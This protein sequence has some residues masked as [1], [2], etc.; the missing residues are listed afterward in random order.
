M[1]EKT[2]VAEEIIAGAG[3][4]AWEEVRLRLATLE[5]RTTWLSTVRPNGVPHVVPVFAPWLDGAL[6]F[7]TGQNTQKERNIAHNPTCA[8][9]VSSQGMDLVV[10][11]VAERVADEASLTPLAALLNKDGWPVTIVEGGFDA[12]YAAPST[13]PAPYNVYRVTP[14]VA[15]AFGT[16]EENHKR[17]TRFRF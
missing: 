3:T 12:P 2:P 14:T 10:E 4:F 16:L 17:P 9:S 13:G 11:G 5:P 7:T 15:F 8:I 6:Y 1:T